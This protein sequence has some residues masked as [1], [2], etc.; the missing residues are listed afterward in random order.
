MSALALGQ[1]V[2]E[3]FLNG[4]VHDGQIFRGDQSH[5]AGHQPTTA[6]Y[7]MIDARIPVCELLGS[8][9]RDD[10][11]RQPIKFCGEISSRINNCDWG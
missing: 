5:E 1:T 7:P 2:V 8:D 3:H 9:V 6:L 4:L 11:L 10:E